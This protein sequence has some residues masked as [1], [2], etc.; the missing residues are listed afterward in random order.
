MGHGHGCLNLR[1]LCV[2]EESQVF[3]LDRGTEVVRGPFA[4]ASHGDI[5]TVHFH[6]GIFLVDMDSLPLC[7][8]EAAP[9]EDVYVKVAL[10]KEQVTLE[11]SIVTHTTLG[12][13]TVDIGALLGNEVDNSR[14]RHTAIER[15]CRSAQHLDLLELLEADTEVGSCRIGAIAV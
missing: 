11:L 2:V 10:A 1:E 9:D 15:R 3:V 4:Y 14:Q 6:T 12:L 5:A 13:D 8:I 7:G